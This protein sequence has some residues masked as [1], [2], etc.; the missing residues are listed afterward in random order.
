MQSRKFGAKP[1]PLVRVE[2]H[3]PNHEDP[4]SEVW[5]RIEL[6]AGQLPSCVFLNPIAT[7]TCDAATPEFFRTTRKLQA[8]WCQQYKAI[9][10]RQALR[11]VKDWV[12][13][14]GYPCH[15]ARYW[16]RAVCFIGVLFLNG[17]F[18]PPHQWP[19]HKL[20]RRHCREQSNPAIPKIP[21][22]QQINRFLIRE[23][24]S[25]K[26]SCQTDQGH[27][28]KRLAQNMKLLGLSDTEHKLNKPVRS[29]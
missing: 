1:K 20:K 10:G 29:K 2:R 15:E 7:V 17:D 19:D 21:P 8:K 14:K 5:K 26:F 25:E 28:H 23:E 16:D 24:M 9:F 3:E 6:I 11:S 22:S 27:K 4:G 12:S 13:W 18:I